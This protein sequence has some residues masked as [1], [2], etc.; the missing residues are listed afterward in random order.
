MM[1]MAQFLTY[2][3]G[4]IKAAKETYSNQTFPHHARPVEPINNINFNNN[5]FLSKKK[6]DDVQKRSIITHHEWIGVRLVN[7]FPYALL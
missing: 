5:M 7:Q 3:V 1:I 6:H 4:G 2:E